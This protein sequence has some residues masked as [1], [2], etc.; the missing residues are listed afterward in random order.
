MIIPN[1]LTVTLY[2]QNFYEGESLIIEGPASIDFAKS[3]YSDW[4][5]KV[6]SLRV[7]ETS[8]FDVTTYWQRV[9]SNNGPISETI[10]VGWSKEQ[11]H[12]TEVSVENQFTAALEAG[13]SFAGASVKTTLTYSLSVGVKTAAQSSISQSTRISKQVSCQSDS[14]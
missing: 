9:I 13:Y 10:E 3:D 1:G 14:V 5:K 7:I 11:S 4:N 2:K 8:K 12:T 6:K